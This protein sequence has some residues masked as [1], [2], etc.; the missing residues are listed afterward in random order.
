[1]MV[2][3]YKVKTLESYRVKVSEIIGLVHGWNKIDI[4]LGNS[5]EIVQWNFF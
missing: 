5:D 1:M 3:S 4:I 2:L